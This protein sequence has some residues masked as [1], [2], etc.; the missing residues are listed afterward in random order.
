M[1]RNV[2]PSLE[3]ITRLRV[4][5]N[6]IVEQHSNARVVCSPFRQTKILLENLAINIKGKG[7]KWNQVQIDTK[8]KT[9][10]SLEMLKVRWHLPS[11]KRQCLQNLALFRKDSQDLMLGHIH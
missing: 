10:I 9:S 11:V 5:I 3:E 2:I 7:A 6:P 8:M 4:P 1:P